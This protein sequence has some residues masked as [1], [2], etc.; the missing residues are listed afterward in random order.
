MANIHKDRLID[1][2]VFV[3]GER[4]LGTADVTLPT[5]SYQTETLSGAGIAG[6]METPALGHTES[7]EVEINWRTV[8]SDLFELFE[9]RSHS[10]EFRG[11]NQYYDAGNGELKVVPVAVFVK[12][13][14][15]ETDMGSMESNS[16]SDSTTTMECTYIKVVIDGVTKLEIDKPNYVHKVNGK[17]YAADIRSALGL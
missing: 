10:L 12:A 9:P 8:N 17:D 4:K 3:E 14:P 13:L 11:A 2:T 16:T 5:L 15:K 1:F 7:S 6:E